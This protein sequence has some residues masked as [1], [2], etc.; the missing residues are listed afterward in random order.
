MLGKDSELSQ[1]S[2]I[3]KANN[4]GKST[5][6][7]INERIEILRFIFEPSPVVLNG[8]KI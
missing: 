5:T 2:H 1:H 4:K 8:I 3:M 7:I 6:E